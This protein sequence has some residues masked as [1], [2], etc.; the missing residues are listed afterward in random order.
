MQAIVRKLKKAP[1]FAFNI[2]TKIGFKELCT[3]Y[4][5]VQR[6]DLIDALYA[7]TRRSPIAVKLKNGFGKQEL[8]GFLEHLQYIKKSVG[9]DLYLWTYN[10]KSCYATYNQ[11]LGLHQEYLAGAFEE[12]YAYD[13][14]DKVVIDVGGFVGD[15]AL[16]FFEQGDREVII[17]EPFDVNIKALNYNLLP[18]KGHFK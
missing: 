9:D 1:A 11:F 18:Y 10:N 4:K 12:M 14:Q 7:R 2:V 15:S 16:F 13:W 8:N 17:Y 6:S 3:I 5:H